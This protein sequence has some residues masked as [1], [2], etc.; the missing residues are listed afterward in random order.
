MSTKKKDSDTCP[1]CGK[2]VDTLRAVI[3]ITEVRNGMGVYMED[4]T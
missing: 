2:L 3:T 1:Y 4:G